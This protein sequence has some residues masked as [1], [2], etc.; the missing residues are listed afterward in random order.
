MALDFSFTDEHE[1]LRATVRAFLEK[2][3]PEEAVREQ[4]ASE[5]GYDPGVWKQMAEE[6]GLAG[7][8]IDEEIGRAHV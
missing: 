2:R 4:M 7:L 5:R 8:I 1:E 3:S 6:L